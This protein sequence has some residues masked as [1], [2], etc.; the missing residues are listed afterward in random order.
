MVDNLDGEFLHGVTVFQ[1]L[2]V[3]KL[4]LLMAY[5]RGAYVR[6]ERGGG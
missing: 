6:G 5:I 3:D 4:F 1:S 2:V